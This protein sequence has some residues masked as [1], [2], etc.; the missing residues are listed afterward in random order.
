MIKIK[1][2]ENLVKVG[3]NR[4]MAMDASDEVMLGEHTGKLR[5]HLMSFHDLLQ[6][7]K[8]AFAFKCREAGWTSGSVAQKA[9]QLE[10]GLKKGEL[11]DKIAKG[12]LSSTKQTS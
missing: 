6:C 5:Q 10:E 8:K 11:L 1:R 4:I 12:L 2:G 3:L 9:E 7:T